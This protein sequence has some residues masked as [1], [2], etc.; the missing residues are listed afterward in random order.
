MSSPLSSIKSVIIPTTDASATIEVP[1]GFRQI[2]ITTQPL[3][4]TGDTSGDAYLVRIGFKRFTS[5]NTGYGEITLDIGQ[6]EP[7]LDAPVNFPRGSGVNNA[8]A[9]VVTELVFSGNDFVGNGGSLYY[10]SVRGNTS[11]YD[12]RYLIARAHKAR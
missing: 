7:I 2:S 8:R 5:S 12:I 11:I 10:E 6:D 1:L 3:N 4:L 9:F